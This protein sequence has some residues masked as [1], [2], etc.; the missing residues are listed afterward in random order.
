GNRDGT[1]RAEWLPYSRMPFTPWRNAVLIGLCRTN[2][3]SWRTQLNR[4]A[5]PGPPRIA[6]L[7]KANALLRRTPSTRGL[8]ASLAESGSFF[9]KAGGLCSRDPNDRFPSSLCSRIE[10]G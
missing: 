4:F 3:N 5:P 10:R 8:R 6:S 9:L 7:G 2:R 1:R